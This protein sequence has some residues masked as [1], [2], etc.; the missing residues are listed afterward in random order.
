[1]NKKRVFPFGYQMRDGQVM[2]NPQ[3]ARLVQEIFEQYRLGK[4]TP[5]LA[6]SAM[7]QGV[8]Y[9][10]G[11]AGWNKNMVCRILDDSR[12]AG[13]DEYPP[14]VE[15]ALY[16][17]VYVQRSGGR[18]RK[19]LLPKEVREKIICPKCGRTLC[20]A[21]CRHGTVSWGCPD[22]GWESGW[23][24]DNQLLRQIT[25]ILNRLIQEPALAE[26]GASNAGVLSVDAMRLAREINRKLG[27]PKVDTDALL[28][29][30]QQ[31]TQE[32]YR[33]CTAIGWENRRL[34]E[35]LAGR[36]PGEALD[37]ALF[38]NIVKSVY[39]SGGEISIRLINGVILS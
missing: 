12:Y 4:T 24:E 31:C 19:S 33:V 3:E 39:I 25:A 28:H 36:Q 22:C 26:K 16:D 8:P 21:A 9:R 15:Q 7:L 11:A 38:E 17:A 13:T 10:E 30:I 37:T 29:L 27:D 35:S 34:V 14:I 5:E 20:R 2:V 6:A 23:M 1:M 18:Q 32:K